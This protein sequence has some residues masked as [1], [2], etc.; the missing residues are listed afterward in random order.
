MPDDKTDVWIII[1]LLRDRERDSRN[2]GDWAEAKSID[3]Q[4]LDDVLNHIIDNKMDEIIGRVYRNGNL[5]TIKDA[6]FPLLGQALELG[7]TI[8]EVQME[9]LFKNADD[10][11]E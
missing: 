10:N 7:Y 4:S 3:P 9:E 6:L 1:E 2:P 8:G 11:R 5:N